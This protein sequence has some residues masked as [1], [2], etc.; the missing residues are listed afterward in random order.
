[1]RVTPAFMILEELDSAAEFGKTLALEIVEEETKPTE[2]SVKILTES[3][4]QQ[5]YDEGYEVGYQAATAQFEVILSQRDEEVRTQLSTAQQEFAEQCG[6]RLA[7]DLSMAIREIKADLARDAA[8]TILPFI[9][10]HLREKAVD[11]LAESITAFT[12]DGGQARLRVTGPVALIDALQERLP[13]G[14]LLTATADES[15][16]ELSVQVDSRLFRTQIAH[17]VKRVEEAS[18]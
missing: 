6:A 9:D 12:G 16:P 11:D 14:W 18:A 2:Q 3:D 5:A 7:E 13:E 10:A 15:N 17:W 8:Q 1:M 4:L